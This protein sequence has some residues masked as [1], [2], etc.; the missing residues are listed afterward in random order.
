MVLALQEY[1][2][3]L[4]PCT[5][6]ACWKLQRIYPCSLTS[7]LKSYFRALTCFC[8]LGRVPLLVLPLED[9]GSVSKEAS[10]VLVKKIKVAGTILQGKALVP[11][12][13]LLGPQM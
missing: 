4:D 5:M 8:S 3:T 6:E 2:I 13:S 11:Q 10:V 1:F 12:L 7:L 9:L